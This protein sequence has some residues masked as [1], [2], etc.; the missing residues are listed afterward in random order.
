MKNI[1]LHNPNDDV[2]PPENVPV[3]VLNKKTS[4]VGIAIYKE[5]KWYSY[6]YGNMSDVSNVDFQWI[7]IVD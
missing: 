5:G 4:I 6:H 1:I 3:F 2:L 7:E